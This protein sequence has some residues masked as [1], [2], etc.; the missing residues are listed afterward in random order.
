MGE[1]SGAGNREGFMCIWGGEGEGWSQ[2]P[3]ELA[4]LRSYLEASDSLDVGYHP[5]RDMLHGWV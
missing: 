1:R 4:Q 3:Q 2:E 5:E